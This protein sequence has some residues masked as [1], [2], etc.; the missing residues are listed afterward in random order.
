M[1][2]NKKY[3]ILITGLIIVV[4]LI[5]YQNTKFKKEIEYLQ[6]S[7]SNM[8]SNLDRAINNMSNSISNEVGNLLKEQENVVSDYKST[9]KGIDTDKEIVKTLFEFTLKESDGDSKVCINISTHDD[10]AGKEYEC[11]TTDGLNYSCQVE[12]SYK[13]D[14][15]IYMY[16]KSADGSSNR[17]NSE[18]YQ[19]NVKNQFDNRVRLM[20]SGT[21]TNDEGTDFS[22]SLENKT[23]GEQSLK[24]KSVVVKAF[25]GDKEVFAQDVTDYNIV[26]SKALDRI[27]LMIAAGDYDST[28]V[29][30]IEYSQISTD[31]NGNEYGNY[32]VNIMHSET[33]AAV[34]YNNYPDYSYKVIVTFNNGDVIEL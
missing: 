12:L 7:I 32:I 6:M 9:Y 8:G 10:T 2:N 13:E 33:G 11:M 20:G 15:I 24:V 18:S 19:D 31:N 26:N 17:L 29:Q 3:N 1:D 23:F 21:S 30:E 34:E 5:I 14:Y 25:Y 28:Q 4:I 16:Q 22:F 27:N